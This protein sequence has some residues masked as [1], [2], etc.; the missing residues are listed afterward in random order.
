MLASFK[1][2][3]AV[4]KVRTGNMEL[5]SGYIKNIPGPLLQWN[6]SFYV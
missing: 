3:L 2:I 1:A 5:L 6:N 4:C